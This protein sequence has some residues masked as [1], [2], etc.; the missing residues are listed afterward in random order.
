MAAGGK[1]RCTIIP[2]PSPVRPWQ[3][4][5]KYRSALVRAK[6]FRASLA[7]ESRDELIAYFPGIKL[8]VG[9]EL[10]AGDGMRWRHARAAR[11]GEEI[12]FGERLEV[13]LIDHAFA[14][15]GGGERKDNKQGTSQQLLSHFLDLHDFLSALFFEKGT[16]FFRA[17]EMILRLDAK[18]ESCLAGEFEIGRVEDRVIG[19]GKPFMANIPISRQRRRRGPLTRR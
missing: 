13:M 18:E 5:N 9:V 1:P 11:V 15:G 6:A 10:A 3:T 17:E 19:L 4:R 7:R 16:H 8:F 2:L 14:A 12:I